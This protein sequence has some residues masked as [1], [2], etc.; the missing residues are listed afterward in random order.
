MIRVTFPCFG[1]SEGVRCGEGVRGKDEVWLASYVTRSLRHAG[2]AAQRSYYLAIALRSLEMC[3]VAPHACSESK[4]LQQPLGPL[5]SW[6]AY[7]ALC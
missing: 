3:L 7:A 4:A 2:N 6:N 5:E 1:L